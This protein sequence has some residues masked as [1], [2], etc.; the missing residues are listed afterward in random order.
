MK[1]FVLSLVV[2]I[3]TVIG[4]FWPVIANSSPSGDTTVDTAVITDYNADFTLARDGQLTVDEVLTVDLPSGKHG[5]FQFWDV[6]DADPANKGVRYRPQDIAITMD[7]Q[8]VPF[9]LS[10]EQ[11]GRFKVARIGDANSF[12]TPGEHRYQISYRVADTIGGGD[13]GRFIWRVVG[14]GWRMRMEKSTST[15]HFPENPTSF[16]C[17]TND[18]SPCEVAEPDATTRVVTTGPLAPNTG[19]AVKAELPFAGPGRTQLPW[20]VSMDVLLGNSRLVPIVSVLLSLLTFAAGFLWMRRSRE[21][22]PLLPVMYEPPADPQKPSRKLGP[23]ETYYVA[24]E[25]M[26]RKALVSTLFHLAEQGHVTLNRTTSSDWTV[27]SQLTPGRFASLDP[28]S[29]AVVAALGLSQAGYV[30]EADGSKSAGQKLSTATKEMEAATRNWGL[31]SGSLERSRSELFGRIAVGAALVVAAVLLIFQILPAQIMA[32]PIAAFVIGGAGLFVPGVGTRRTPLGREVWSRSGGFERLL[33]TTSN[34]ER[35]DF[36]ARKELFTSYIPYAMAFNCADAWA[37]KYR[38]ATG[39]EPPDPVWLP[40][41][42]VGSTSHGLF[43]GGSGM[44]SFESSL[45]SSLSAYSSSQS[46]SGSGGGFGGGFGGGG[47]GGGGGGS[48]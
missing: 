46:S 29:N 30:F 38:Y 10:E 15:V 37:A 24:Y 44:D 34:Q 48:W 45:S 8:P 31:Q 19:V 40:G 16:A 4:L 12:V 21:D 27:V 1:R 6:S 22:T 5:I 47:G 33:S 39:Q 25:S 13:P 23:V 11:G 7:G 41:F 26:P 18:G 20:S 43:G 35:L 9:E 17:S 14:N 3:A 42:Y 28:A 2:A 32:L 36:S